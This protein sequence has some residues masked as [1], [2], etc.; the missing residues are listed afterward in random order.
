MLKKIINWGLKLSCGA[1]GAVLLFIVS[2]STGT[3]SVMGMHEPQMPDS[4][5]P[6][7]GE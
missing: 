4:L 3:M 1:V 2:A 7:D 6:K 5:I